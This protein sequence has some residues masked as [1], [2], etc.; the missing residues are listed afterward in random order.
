MSGA[1]VRAARQLLAVALVLGACGAPPR[2][3]VQ[4]VSLLGEPLR[5]MAMSDAPRAELEQQLAEARADLA[6]RP[7]DVAAMV[8]VGRRLAYLGRF[9]DAVDVYTEALLRHP[10]EPHL[11]RHRGHRWIT[12]REFDRAVTDLARAAERM[13][14]RPDEIEPDGQPNARG[15]PLSTL[16]GNILYHLG[17]AHFLRGDF[18]AAL[19]VW[20]QARAAAQN[21]DGVCSTAYWLHNTLRRLGRHAEAAAVAAAIRPDMDVVENGAYHRQLLAFA[22]RGHPVALLDAVP[23]G[24][25]SSVEF[26]TLGYGIGNWLLCEGDADGA[27]EVYA[28]VL[29]GEA[30]PAFGHIA[31]EADVA[32]GDVVLPSR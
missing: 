20:Q 21:D 8:W 16:K 27:A 12:L 26:A 31:A 28:R 24:T 30:W 9:R 13:Q 22:A 29:A 14:G 11:L 17:L 32:R 23:P 3:E 7:D 1:S 10:D 4:A 15:V 2:A 19:P 25:A 5:P 18:E 6:A